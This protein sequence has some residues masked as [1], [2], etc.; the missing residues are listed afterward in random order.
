MKLLQNSVSNQ[1]F[2]SLFVKTV[3]KNSD[4]KFYDYLKLIMTAVKKI[5]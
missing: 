2:I 1:E 3:I 4:N 5:V